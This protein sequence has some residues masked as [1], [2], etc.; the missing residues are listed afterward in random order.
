M[1]WYDKGMFCQCGQIAVE[2]LD[3]KTGMNDK[4]V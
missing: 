4:F 1:A 2:T 3:I